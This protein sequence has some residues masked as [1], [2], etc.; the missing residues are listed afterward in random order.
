LRPH[1]LHANLWSPWSGQYGIAAGLLTPGVRVV[2]VEHAAI[3]STDAV[4]RRLRRVLMNRVA[5]HVSVSNSAARQVEEFVGLRPGAVRT[6]YNGV[7]DIPPRPVSRVAQGPVVGTLTRVDP[8]KGL[9]ILLE[10]LTELS[11][12]TGV[13]VGEGPELPALRALAT[14]LGVGDRL[15]T[16][17][18]SVSA[19]DHL[20]GFDVYVLPSRF[21]ALPISIVEAMLAGLPV[22]ASNVGGVPEVVEPEATGLLVAPGDPGALAAALRRLLEDADLRRSMGERGRAIA[23]ERFSSARMA[24]AYERLYAEVMD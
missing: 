3:A 15:L 18:F 13:I 2:C 10:A 17:G 5:A 14:R 22:V 19:R 9:D 4:Q 12:V 6:I 11:G 8:H 23:G 20:T 16:P 1:I 21:E 7:P 24:R